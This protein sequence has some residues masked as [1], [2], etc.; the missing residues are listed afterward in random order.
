[1]LLKKAFNAIEELK[2]SNGFTL[3]EALLSVVLL[4]LIAA[5][6][7]A[8]FISGLQSLDLQDDRMLLDSPLRSRLEVLIGTDF[9]TL[10]NGSEVVTVNGQNYTITWTVVNVD[11]DGDATSEP[12][13]KHIG[14]SVT[15]VPGRSLTTIVVDH[16]GRVGKIS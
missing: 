10:S 16:E 3:V 1:M 9:G 8:P 11:L 6:I 4:A 12:N 2:T 13:V 15:E 7:T 14:V 5:G